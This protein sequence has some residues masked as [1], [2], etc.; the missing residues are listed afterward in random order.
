MVSIEPIMVGVP[1]YQIHDLN[2]IPNYDIAL[3]FGVTLIQHH[4]KLVDP[5]YH[6]FIP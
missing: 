1:T 2:R 5:D 4:I 6:P 3:V